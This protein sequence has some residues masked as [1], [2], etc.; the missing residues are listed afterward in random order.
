MIF[1]NIATVDNGASRVTTLPANM[2]VEDILRKRLAYLQ[3]Y[4]IL[5]LWLH[6]EV[7]W[8]VFYAYSTT[9]Q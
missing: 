1:T 8:V 5:L 2:S 9:K 6:N 3:K 7:F 4:D